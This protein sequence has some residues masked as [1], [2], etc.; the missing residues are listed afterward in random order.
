MLSLTLYDILS[1]QWEPK[2][3]C[4]GLKIILMCFVVLSLLF[5]ISLIPLHPDPTKHLK[6]Y[7]SSLTIHFLAVVPLS[8]FGNYS[9]VSNEAFKVNFVFL[10]ISGRNDSP[11]SLLVNA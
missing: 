11:R 3:V 6:Y 9:S 4:Q 2:C 1:K 5:I 7:E 8:L 10:V